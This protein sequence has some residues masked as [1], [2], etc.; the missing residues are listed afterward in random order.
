MELHYQSIPNISDNSFK[1]I[2][3][4][5]AIDN[6]VHAK[7]Q[8]QWDDNI[9]D[10]KNDAIEYFNE[11]IDNIN[12]IDNNKKLYHQLK[13]D[14]VKYCIISDENHTSIVDTDWNNLD[15]YNDHIKFI[16]NFQKKFEYTVNYK[17]KPFGSYL[18]IDIQEFIININKELFCRL[19]KFVKIHTDPLIDYLELKKQYPVALTGGVHHQEGH[20]LV[21]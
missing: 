6:F 5:T 20:P 9:N 14:L 16:K 15:K 4:D 21:L 1:L 7:C 10:A 19:N 13:S 8:K 2:I 11:C 12:D 18:P 3:E 17:E